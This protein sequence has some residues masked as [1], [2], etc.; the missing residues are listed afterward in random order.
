MGDRIDGQ[1]NRRAR[2]A[3]RV[4]TILLGIEQFAPEAGDHLG[5]HDTAEQPHPLLDTGQVNIDQLHP[6]VDQG[7]LGGSHAGRHLI[8][9]IVI[10]MGGR[11]AQT[12]PLQTP[13]Q[14]N[15]NLV[16]DAVHDRRVGRR[17]TQGTNRI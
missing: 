16:H 3:D 6:G 13:R 10:E 14:R 1:P 9:Q 8:V 15:F 7:G 4:H 12:Q 11:A 17:A 2:R 5:R